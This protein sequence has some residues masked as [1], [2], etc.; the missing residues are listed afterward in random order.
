VKEDEGSSSTTTSGTSNMNE[1]ASVSSVASSTNT[2][3]I[4]Y[5]VPSAKTL[6]LNVVEVSG[7][8]IAKFTVKIDDTIE[9]LRRTFYGNLNEDFN[10]HGL[11]LTAG[12][13]LKVEVFHQNSVAGDFDVRLTGDLQ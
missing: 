4:T 7:T 6:Y 13:V 11:K 9:G 8:N 2:N 3:L 1:T 10:F 12:Q 5:T